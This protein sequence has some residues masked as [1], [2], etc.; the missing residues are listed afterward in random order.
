MKETLE[1]L[2]KF[3]KKDMSVIK[4]ALAVALKNIGIALHTISIKLVSGSPR[5]Y[6]TA[7]AN[8]FYSKPEEDI[9][10]WLIKINRMIKA[11]NVAT[12]R[13]VVV[14]AAHLRDIIMD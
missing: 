10:E 8:Y 2:N 3:L 12:E 7:K 9:E 4:K 14:V 5:E 6:N 13:R 11:N 1:I